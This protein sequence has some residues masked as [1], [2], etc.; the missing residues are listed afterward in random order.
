M[1]AAFGLYVETVIGKTLKAAMMAIPKG[2]TD[3]PNSASQ[4]LAG[5]VMMIRI[6]RVFISATTITKIA[7]TQ[8]M[9]STTDSR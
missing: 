2:V 4:K 8:M 7:L 1:I 5:D 3:V 6:S 9:G